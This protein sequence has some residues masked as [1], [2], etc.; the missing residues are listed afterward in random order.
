MPYH[1]PL[2]QEHQAL[3]AQMVT[4]ANYMMPIHYGSQ[5]NEHHAVRQSCGM[6]D[7][8]HMM[9][10]EI[11]GVEAT[12]FLQYLLMGDVARLRDGRALYSAMLNAAGGI[13]DD[14]IVYRINPTTYRLISNAGTREKVTAWLKQQAQAFAVN[15]TQ[16]DD[17]AI[18]A[19]QGS[20][21]LSQVNKALDTHTATRVSALKP[22]SFILT[23]D[24]WQIAKTGYTGEAG[25]EI[26]LPAD[27]AVPFW[28]ALL[29]HGVAPVGLGARDTLR[30]EAGLNL[31]GQDMDATTSPLVANMEKFVSMA[32]GRVFIGR[33]ALER[34]KH[35]GVTQQLVGL[36][37]LDKGVL[38]TGQVVTISDVG[39]GVV[40]SGSF[41]PTLGKSIALAR[42]PINA[43]KDTPCAVQIRNKQLAAQVVP[44][45]F[46]SKA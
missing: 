23:A 39:E 5:I 21:A 2:F 27:A 3:H 44:L 29:Q 40:T 6:F 17:I 24:H 32:N 15:V 38:R 8:S 11:E 37:L 45:P 13:I 18:I 4:F 42:V 16:M 33:S 46:V 35:Q 36:I 41:S 28:R 7:V 43:N 20:K 22:F 26:V 34:Q 19:I 1:T 10:S 25:L 12:A 30:L 31:Y 14:L 9:L